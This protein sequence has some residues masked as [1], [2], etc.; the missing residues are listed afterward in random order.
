MAATC[1]LLKAHYCLLGIRDVRLSWTAIKLKE[2]TTTQLGSSYSIRHVWGSWSWHAAF[3]KDSLQPPSSFGR[4][5]DPNHLSG[6]S[7]EQGLRRHQLLFAHFH[8]SKM[9]HHDTAQHFST[10]TESDLH[11]ADIHSRKLVFPCVQHIGSA[12]LAMTYAQAWLFHLS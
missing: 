1:F 4:H 7:I 10:W 6:Y 12:H 5:V 2:S 3:P 8:L 11:Q 9:I